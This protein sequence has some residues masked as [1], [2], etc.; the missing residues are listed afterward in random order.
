M[1]LKFSI[2][3]T[4]CLQWQQNVCSS[5]NGPL[6]R[7][8]EKIDSFCLT[9]LQAAAF[10]ISWRLIHVPMSGTWAGKTQELRL[11]SLGLSRHSYPY[12]I[13]PRCWLHCDHFLMWW[14]RAP[15]MS[16][17]RKNQEETQP[18]KCHL[19]FIIFSHKQIPEAG[20]YSRRWKWDFTSCERISKDLQMIFKLFLY[21]FCLFTLSYGCQCL[22]WYNALASNPAAGSWLLAFLPLWFCSAC[23]PITV[24][25]IRLY[26]RSLFYYKG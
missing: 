6:G 12:I 1:T 23:L 9:L 18:W 21:I 13:S 25:L 26:H 5:G 11:V 16:V 8:G 14:I 19:C 22:H 4:Q 3:S 10:W 20:L 2:P 7:A 17:P 15:K 24:L